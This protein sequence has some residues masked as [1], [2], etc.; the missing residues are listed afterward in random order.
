MPHMDTRVAHA[1]AVAIEIGV[2]KTSELA[3]RWTVKRARE[4]VQFA[5]RCRVSTALEVAELA[6][7]IIIVCSS[8]YWRHMFLG[9]R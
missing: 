1:T 5:G 6:G 2:L 7:L 9:W 3:T 8:I 4:V